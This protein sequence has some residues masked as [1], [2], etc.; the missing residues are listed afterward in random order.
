MYMLRCQWSDAWWNF[1]YEIK[2]RVSF[3]AEELET[4][5][6]VKVR[7]STLNVSI[8]TVAS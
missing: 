4:V 5:E 1:D 3:I 7:R 2:A 8:D 6:H